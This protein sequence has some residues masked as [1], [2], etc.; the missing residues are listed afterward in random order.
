MW[1]ERLRVP[2]IRIFLAMRGFAI[3]TDA[4]FG[5]LPFENGSYYYEYRTDIILRSTMVGRVKVES[6]R[7]DFSTRTEKHCESKQL[8]DRRT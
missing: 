2:S 8:T 7:D 1:T 5:I 4:E 6:R 3:S